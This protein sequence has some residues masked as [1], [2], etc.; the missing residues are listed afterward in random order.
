MSSVLLSFSDHYAVYKS[1]I[2][3][4]L[5]IRRKV[6]IAEFRSSHD[7]CLIKEY[8]SV[9]LYCGKLNLTRFIISRG[10]SNCT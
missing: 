1:T 2:L 9:Y 5:T 8:Q 4:F 10:K 6:G 7:D 3:T